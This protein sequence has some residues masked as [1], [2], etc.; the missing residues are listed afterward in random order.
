MRFVN[1]KID[2]QGQPKANSGIE[3]IMVLNKNGV[4]FIGKFT[5]TTLM[6]HAFTEV[7]NL[8]EII[9]LNIFYCY[10]ICTKMQMTTIYITIFLKQITSTKK[11]VAEDGTLFLEMKFDD[12]KTTQRIQTDQVNV[13]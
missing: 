11:V 8:S 3:H 9:F 4:S 2:C 12:G 13:H 7:Q 1:A 6:H 5:H 10:I